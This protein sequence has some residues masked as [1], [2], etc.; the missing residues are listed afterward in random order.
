MSTDRIA[1]GATPPDS[2]L[3]ALLGLDEGAQ[4]SGGCVVAESAKDRVQLPGAT[5]LADA[6]I[7]AR[8]RSRPPAVLVVESL[9][10]ALRRAL[11]DAAP[12]LLVIT[13]DDSPELRQELAELSDELDCPILGPAATLHAVPEGIRSSPVLACAASR[14][15]L[16]GLSRAFSDA[17]PPVLTLCPTP[18]WLVRWLRDPRL[19][20]VQAVG[21]VPRESLHLGWAQWMRDAETDEDQAAPER[22]VLV[23][24]GL[25]R[26]PVDRPRDRELDVA[27]AGHALERHTGP[28]YPAP[29]VLDLVR[30]GEPRTRSAPREDAVQLWAQARRAL[31]LTGG[32]LGMDTPLP[33]MSLDAPTAAFLAQRV[34]LR[35]RRC[36]ELLG[37][38][39]PSPVVL[40]EPAL[41]D[42]AREVLAASG[43]TLSEHESKVVLRGFGVEIT[44]QAVANS[45]SGAAQFAD[46][47]GYPVV[48]KVL[49]PDLRRKQEAG[50]VVLDLPNAAAVRRA[51]AAVLRAVED[52][53]PTARVDGVVVAEMIGPGT[54]VHC[55][56]IRLRSGEVALHGRVV[57]IPGPTEPLLALAPL[58]PTAA[59]LH[60]HAV[61]SQVP[62]PALRRAS[63][64][65]VNVLARLFRRL[66][67]IFEETEDRLLSIDMGPIRLLPAD[68]D[69]EREYVTL[70]A[71]ITQRA[72][73][74]GL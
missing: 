13:G 42:R 4:G 26:A 54:E 1:M 52:E 25:N 72:H 3:A 33:G 7:P 37:E 62:V 49:S 66:S 32:S 44:R 69:D 41:V 18:A 65:D 55:G 34:L 12:G 46:R 57:G 10:A 68:N 29:R 45:A 24:L 15:E 47:I 71:V 36:Q 20:G 2:V 59:V 27:V 74:E 61:L 39:D 63:D 43:E 50:A 17:E 67:M 35:Q 73:L 51:Y 40:P 31:P 19:A 58:T 8:L 70:D 14:D 38:L 11:R 9:S 5:L 21:Y 60:A 16:A 30:T 48:L 22:H 56:A 6:K 64:P 28:I 23:P 53:A